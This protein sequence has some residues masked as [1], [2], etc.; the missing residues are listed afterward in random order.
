VYVEYNLV[1]IVVD[2]ILFIEAM[3]DYVKIFTTTSAKPIITKIGLKAM[4]EKLAGRGFVRIHKSYMVAVDKITAIKR[5]I[6][7]LSNTELPLS[8]SYREGVISQLKS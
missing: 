2:E 4:E 7:C 1:K 3:K 5:D 8:E 6:I